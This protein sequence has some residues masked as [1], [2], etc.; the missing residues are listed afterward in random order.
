MAAEANGPANPGETET[1]LLLADIS[2]YT[3][4]MLA[5]HTER[6]HAHGIIADLLAAVITEVKLPL[7]VNKLEGDAIL[8]FAQAEDES[9]QSQAR[10]IGEKL[11]VFTEAFR[12]KLLQL[13]TSNICK[14]H[15]CLHMN[16]LRLKLIGHYGQALRRTVSGFDEILG[17][18]VIVVHRLLKNSIPDAEYRLFT[19]RA[20]KLLRP[21]GEYRR[22]HENYPDVG[23]I[24]LHLQVLDYA[25]PKVAVRRFSLQ[26]MWRKV[27]Y[28][29]R[30]A[31]SR[32]RHPSRTSEDT[33]A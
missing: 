19:D 30:Y 12:H 16:E 6:V 17:I 11:D 31:F 23:K 9:W 15:S 4:F 5:N 3:G 1:L 25:P 8:M 10:H 26:D 14:C 7:R 27:T 22:H 18:D 28:D 32:N 29:V 24:D 33:D 13:A 21:P 20:F 2:G